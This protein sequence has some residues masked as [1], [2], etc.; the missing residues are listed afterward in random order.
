MTCFEHIYFSK[1]APNQNSGCPDTLDAPPPW[2]RHCTCRHMC[3][4]CQMRAIPSHVL[5]SAV[6][7]SVCIGHR[8]KTCT[9]PIWPCRRGTYWRHLANTV[10]RSMLNGDASCRYH[11]CSNLV[12]RFFSKCVCQTVTR[13]KS[14]LSHSRCS[15]L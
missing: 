13:F 6:C 10:E 12:F 9:N 4:Q 15:T 1:K 11:Y 8:E 3:K 14:Q 7:V 2:I 5:T